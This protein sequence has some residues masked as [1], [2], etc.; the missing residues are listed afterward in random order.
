MNGWSDLSG[1]FQRQAAAL[2]PA[3]LRDAEGD[4]DGEKVGDADGGGEAAAVAIDAGLPRFATLFPKAQKLIDAVQPRIDDIVRLE[5]ARTKKL[6]KYGIVFEQAL[7][8]R[9]RHASVHVA[10]AVLGSALV[11]VAVRRRRRAERARDAGGG[12]KRA[13]AEDGGDDAAVAPA[14]K[15]AYRI[16]QLASGFD[17]NTAALFHMLSE[18]C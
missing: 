1:R 6:D 16:Y 8:T 18:V 13:G 10:S 15:L 9:A 14:L 11:D 4:A 12:G 5:D 2:P 3:A 7:V 17:T